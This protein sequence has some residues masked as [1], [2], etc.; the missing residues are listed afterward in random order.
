MTG[1]LNNFNEWIRLAKI[2]GMR[3]AI[4]KYTT[5]FKKKVVRIQNQLIQTMAQNFEKENVDLLL[6]GFNLGLQTQVVIVVQDIR[7]K[8]LIF[9][10]ELIKSINQLI[11]RRNIFC[12]YWKEL[13][14]QGKTFGIGAH[15]F[16]DFFLL[17]K[18][19]FFLKHTKIKRSMVAIL[20]CDFMGFPI[21]YVYKIQRAFL[22]RKALTLENVASNKYFIHPYVI[23]VC[24]LSSKYYIHE[25]RAL[26]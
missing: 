6:D 3:E 24:L 17:I 20:K 25:L 26:F 15:I 19:N 13:Q 10:K 11:N 16:K 21:N 18:N 7:Q 14:L 1:T 5:C 23:N 4:E 12:K 8:I 22:D 9:I 2:F